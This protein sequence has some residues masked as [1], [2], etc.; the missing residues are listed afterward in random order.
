MAVT[1]CTSTKEA[2]AT[3]LN[4]HCVITTAQ[5]A[6]SLLKVCEDVNTMIFLT[7]I[8]RVLHPVKAISLNYDVTMVCQIVTV[9]PLVYYLIADIVLPPRYV[10]AMY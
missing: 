6:S 3:D 5:L 10:F 7:V 8:F 9:I 2:V 1:K 4:D